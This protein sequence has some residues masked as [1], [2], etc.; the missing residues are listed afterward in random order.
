MT[1]NISWTRSKARLAAVWYVW[2]GAILMILIFQSSVGKY[3]EQATLAWQWL[4]PTILPTLTLMIGVF[5]VDAAEKKTSK[6]A[7]VSRHI[8]R[9]TVG[10]SIFYLLTVSLTLFLEPI[11]PISGLELMS[12]SNLWLGPFQGVTTAAIGI[13]FM[14]REAAE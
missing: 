5:A 7:V 1:N 12:L 13:F 3:G 4:L 6:K 11:T 14:K 10:I 8:F 9:L 2:S